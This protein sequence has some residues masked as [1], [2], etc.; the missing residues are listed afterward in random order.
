MG[1]L[2]TRSEP[3][4]PQQQGLEAMETRQQRPMSLS[5]ES[6]RAHPK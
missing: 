4:G 2:H 6:Q 3:G 1:S 5:S